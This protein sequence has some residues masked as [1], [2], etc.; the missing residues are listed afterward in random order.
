MRKIIWLIIA[1]MFVGIVDTRDVLSAGAAPPSEIITCQGCELI[2]NSRDSFS[3]WVN[4]GDTITLTGPDGYSNYF[5]SGGGKTSMGK[6]FTA[7]VES[8]A[9][10]TLTLDG[11]SRIKTVQVSL[12]SS[13]QNNC[14]P[15]PTI[16]KVDDVEIVNT[17]SLAPGQ[18][19]SI[20]AE[21]DESEC[22]YDS[23]VD[24]S[25]IIEGSGL[26]I[27]NPGALETWLVVKNKPDTGRNPIL[28]AQIVKGLLRREA[29]ITLII[30]DNMPPTIANLY[31]YTPKPPLSNKELTINCDNCKTGTGTNEYGDFISSL[32]V[33]V[34]NNKDGIV[35]A[36]GSDSVSRDDNR[37]PE[38]SITLG[39]ECDC[40]I[41]VT[42]TDSFGAST[43]V[44][45]ILP[46]EFGNT[47][48][49]APF[50]K[51]AE[52]VPCD[53]FECTFD[54]QGSEENNRP[55][56]Y[57]KFEVRTI[58]GSFEPLFDK[59]RNP[60]S[61]PVCKTVFA[62]PGIYEVKITMQYIRDGE[63]SGK[64]AEKTVLV[65]V[66]GVSPPATSVPTTTRKPLPVVTSTPAPEPTGTW[67]PVT[68]PPAAPG[69][70]GK[71]YECPK[72]PGVGIFEAITVIII[73]F[74]QKNK[75]RKN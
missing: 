15:I 2:Q 11:G 38:V 43:T 64:I 1:V 51:L 49:G 17:V 41:E 57:R 62:K 74:L 59:S 70:C 7:E 40:S 16:I 68:T 61:A 63:P 32:S 24:F 75:K 10:Y 47:E 50:I 56:L 60:C 45:D 67:L 55:G 26:F 5:W 46:I 73:A 20:S 71:D 27:E 54:T 36:S 53:G 65:S 29:N 18:R 3:T 39:D 44:K 9:V 28:K 37:K 42:A 23:S 48:D 69:E 30:K 52:P 19:V 33:V 21:F 31:S 6:S 13:E 35:I 34:R 22:P 66:G 8:D 14:V 4:K 12:A 58:S 72:A 25:W